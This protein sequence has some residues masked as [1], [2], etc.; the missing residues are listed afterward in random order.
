MEYRADATGTSLNFAAVSAA[1]TAFREE[2]AMP[3]DWSAPIA[4]DIK[5]RGRNEDVLLYA[6]KKSTAGVR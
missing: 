6:D 4:A 2:C 1:A 3:Q 5:R